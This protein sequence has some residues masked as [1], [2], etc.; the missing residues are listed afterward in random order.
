MV[1]GPDAV[2]P[3]CRVTKKARLL[4]LKKRWY[5]QAATP[6]AWDGSMPHVTPFHFSFPLTW[7][8][9]TKRVMCQQL[10]HITW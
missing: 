1:S 10:M 3:A 4:A 2:S 7:V 5:V 6:E 9:E 8:R